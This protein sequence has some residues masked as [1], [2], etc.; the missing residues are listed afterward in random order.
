MAEG[1][2]LLCECVPDETRGESHFLG[3]RDDAAMPFEGTRITMVYF[4]RSKYLE[5]KDEFRF[6]LEGLGFSFPVQTDLLFKGTASTTMWLCILVSCRAG[7][8]SKSSRLKLGHLCPEPWLHA[9]ANLSVWSAL[10][11]PPEAV[12]IAILKS[13]T[14]ATGVASTPE[15]CPRCHETELPL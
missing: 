4:S 5:L 15:S 1:T 8:W 13:K 6:T 11:A 7:S 12:K 2:V 14:T 9:E 3:A 10:S